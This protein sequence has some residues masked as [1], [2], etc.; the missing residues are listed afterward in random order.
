MG[1][2]P[3]ISAFP[4]GDNLFKWVGTMSGVAGTVYEGLQFKLSISFPSNYPFTAPTIKFDTPCFHPN[5]DMQGNIC[6]D[7]LKVSCDF[8]NRINGRLFTTFRLFYCHFKACSVS[9]IMIAPSTLKRHN[10]GPIKT[11]EINLNAEFKKIL[12]QKYQENK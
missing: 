1:G 8:M 11:V 2:I 5:V 10:F 7:I 9:P 12:L 3:G 4:D 6:L